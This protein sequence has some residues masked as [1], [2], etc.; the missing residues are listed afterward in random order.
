MSVAEERREEVMRRLR[1]DYLYFPSRALKIIDK[2]G[3]EVVFNLKQPQRRLAAAM[4]RQRDAGLPQ[5][6]VALKARQVGVSTQTQGIAIQRVCQRPN[7]KALIVAQDN[8]TAGSLFDIGNRMWANLPREIRPPLAYF[9]NARTGLKYMQFGEAAKKLR[10]DGVYGLNSVIEIDTANEAQAG[11]G[12]TI[13]TLHLSEV[14]FWENPAKMDSLLNAVPETPESFALVEST[15][16]GA[17]LFKDTWDMAAD[18]SSGFYPHFTPWFEEHEYR[19]PFANRDDE[20]EFETAVGTGPYGEDEPDLLELIGDSIYTWAAELNER[21]PDAGD[22]RIRALEHLHWRRRAIPAK[23]KGSIDTFHQE[24]PSTPDEA[25]LTTGRK[26]FDLKG[27]R[28]VLK[29]VEHTDPV[30]PSIEHPGPEKGRL[31]PLGEREVQSRRG[32][33][34]MVAKGALWIPMDRVEDENRR[35]AQ[36]R[37]WEK[38]DPGDDQAVDINGDPA[39]RLPGQYIAFEDPA[40]GE[41]NEGELAASAIV[42]INHRTLKQCAELE[43]KNLDPDEVAEQLYLAGLYW[44]KAWVAIERTGG[45]GLSGIR[46]VVR[47][48]RYPRFFRMQVEDNNTGSDLDR[49][50]W[51]TN[52]RTKPMMIDRGHELLRTNTDGIRSRRLASQ[53]STYIRDEKGKTKPDAGKLADILMAWLGAQAIAERRPLRTDREKGRGARAV[54]TRTVRSSK[55]GW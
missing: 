33:K 39:P 24:Y 26:V 18:G 46:R 29:A 15:A 30:V 34:I 45:Y 55:T 52:P 40:S 12:L 1:D 9:A 49:A 5:R 37:M 3:E 35:F 51:D 31:K 10:E 47:D 6:A 8:R 53:L 13:H 14:A 25:F 16:F 43:T 2:R 27:V 41:E 42:V 54:R 17:N 28:R 23:C 20:L 19:L 11:R 32:M 50:G 36:W 4:M 48:Y 44:N 21:P 38:P 7:H 22:V